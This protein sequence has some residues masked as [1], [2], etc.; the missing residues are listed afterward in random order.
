MHLGSRALNRTIDTNSIGFCTFGTYTSD[1]FFTAAGMPERELHNSM[2]DIEYTVE[3]FRPI[4]L[5][6]Y[7]F[8]AFEKVELWNLQ[9][10]HFISTPMI[11]LQFAFRKGRS[12]ETALSRTINKIEKALETGQQGIGVFLDIKGAFDNVTLDAVKAALVRKKFPPWFVAWYTNYMQDRCV[13]MEF[14]G[15][16]CTIFLS[17]GTPQGGV[18]SPLIWNLVFDTFIVGAFVVDKVQELGIPLTVL[19]IVPD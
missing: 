18:L 15:A 13:T 11:D 16:S 6:N 10:T 19:F 12:T 9:R 4:T 5:A 17:D 1:E 8:K 7:I 14:G 3:S 2:E